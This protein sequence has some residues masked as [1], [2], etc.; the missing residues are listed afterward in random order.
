MDNCDVHHTL[1]AVMNTLTQE[2][3]NTAST[4][5]I[6]QGKSSTLR[7]C[8]EMLGLWAVAATTTLCFSLI[9]VN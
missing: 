4:K 7:D 6:Q 9:W 8:I 1:G 2:M 3:S 5:H